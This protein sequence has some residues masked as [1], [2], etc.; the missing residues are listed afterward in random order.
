MDCF[1]IHPTISST[2]PLTPFPSLFQTRSQELT[3]NLLCSKD[4][5][6]FWVTLTLPLESRILC[7]HHHSGNLAQGL[8]HLV[9]ILLVGAAPSLLFSLHIAG[10]TVVHP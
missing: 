3:L 6:E 2:L 4:K 5:F 8:V 10:P 7:V 9:T 1:L